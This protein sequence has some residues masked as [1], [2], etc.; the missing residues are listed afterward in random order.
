MIDVFGDMLPFGDRDP[1]RSSVEAGLR[2]SARETDV[3]PPAEE[4]PTEHYEVVGVVGSNAI[5]SDADIVRAAIKAAT[6]G[7]VI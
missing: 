7:R 3:A 4:M 1:F 2:K 5:L 6:K